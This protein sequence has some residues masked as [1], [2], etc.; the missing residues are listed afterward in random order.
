LKPRLLFLA[1]TLPYPPTGGVK[2]RSFHTLRILSSVFDVTALCFYR[3][4]RGRLEPDVE[5]ALERLSQ[6]A[7]VR[8]FPIPSDHS[9]GRLLLDHLRSSLQRSVYTNFTYQSREFEDALGAVLEERDFVVVHSDSLDLSRYFDVMPV[10]CPIVCVHHDAQ[11][12]LLERRA[13]R[14]PRRLIAS[15][16]MFQ[17]HL[18]REEEKYRCASV[19]VNITVSDQDTEVLRS[20]APAGK[21]AVVPNGVDTAFFAPRDAPQSGI[22]FVGG[23]TWFPNRDALVYYAEV[24]LPMIRQKLPGIE[25]TWIG[26]ASDEERRAFEHCEGLTLT[27]F[28]ADIRPYLAS[29]ACF[30][31]PLRVGGGTRIKILDAWAMGKAVVSTSVG[32]EGLDAVPGENILVADDPAAFAEAVATVVRDQSVRERLGRLGRQ[33]VME[34]YSWEVIGRVMIRAYDELTATDLT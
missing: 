6:L 8:A 32:C 33:T 14:E 17:S 19:S 5:R 15:Y 29:A 9:R 10:G 18:M 2:I 34:R 24:L 26:R 13:E 7:D 23:T 12:L 30:V 28:V 11:S 16:L 27:G 22:C 25:T 20:L 31:V 4:K 3:W 21:F 1:Q